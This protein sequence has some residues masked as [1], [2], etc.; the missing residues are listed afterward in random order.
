MMNAFFAVGTII[1]VVILAL[2]GLIDLRHLALAAIFL[3]ATFL[4][5]S[6]AGQLSRFSDGYVRILLLG[7]CAAASL[8]LISR[9]LG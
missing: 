6:L 9:G 4:G 1:A 3:P 7:T 5:L 8:I 2:T